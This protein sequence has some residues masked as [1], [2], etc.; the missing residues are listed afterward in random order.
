MEAVELLPIEE[1]PDLCN[2]TTILDQ[3]VGLGTR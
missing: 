2:V 3:S 1:Q